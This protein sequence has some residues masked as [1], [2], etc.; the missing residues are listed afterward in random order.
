MSL[1]EHQTEPEAEGG[2]RAGRFVVIA[3][4]VAGIGATYV[5]LSRNDESAPVA[6]AD[7]PAA[8][9]PAPAPEPEPEPEPEAPAPEEVPEAEPEEAV[10]TGTS[11]IEVPLPPLLRVDSDVPGAS[12]FLDRKYLGTTPF[13]TADV[14]PGQHRL[15]VSAEGYE[16]FADTVEIG[17]E[18]V[19]IDVRF[20]DVRLDASVAVVHK[21]RFGDC[22]GVLRADLEGL[23]YDTD[24]DDAFSLSFDEIEQHELDYLEHTLTLKERDGRTYNFTDEEETADALFTFHRDVEQARERLGR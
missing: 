13:E 8:A 5:W 9:R 19:S 6:A 16:G 1:L 24:D 3:L 23:H 12:V 20:L 18:L 14:G 11:V 4:L 21:H 7:P 2:S 22:K 10:A 15:N 17:N